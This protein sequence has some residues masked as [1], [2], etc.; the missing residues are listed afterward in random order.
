MTIA[1]PSNTTVNRHLKRFR[2]RQHSSDVNEEHLSLELGII[3]HVN[4]RGENLE[5]LD[6]PRQKE[7]C[8]P[9]IFAFTYLACAMITIVCTRFLFNK[10][11]LRN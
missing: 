11:V 3:R 9:A 2:T 1:H 4:D 6:D 5:S 8:I 10:R 7:D